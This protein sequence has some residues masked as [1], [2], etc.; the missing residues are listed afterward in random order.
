[1]THL[2]HL[3]AALVVAFHY[4]CIY[5]APILAATILPTVITG[6]TDRPSTKDGKL[7]QLAKLAVRFCGWAVHY[8]ETGSVKLPAAELLMLLWKGAVAIYRVFKP[9]P[10]L[11][12]LALGLLV[13]GCITSATK[14]GATLAQ[15]LKDDEAAVQMMATD[16]ATQCGPQFK[17]L[18][19]VF[20]D[21]LAVAADPTN[22][23]ADV[24][25]AAN[26][27][28]ILASDAK[29]TICVVTVIVKDLKALKPAKAALLDRLLLELDAQQSVA[30]LSVPVACDLL[31]GYD[32]KACRLLACD[33]DDVDCTAMA[34]GRFVQPL[35]QPPKATKPVKAENGYLDPMPLGSL[36]IGSAARGGVYMR[37]RYEPLA[38][39]VFG[40]PV[41]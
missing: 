11:L 4:F 24:L 21:I 40:L 27:Y 41:L 5:A 36:T 1:M 37:V 14:P 29:A 9:A 38:L 16:V 17:S 7:A 28:P 3:G 20:S 33:S 2:S 18:T 31:A 8:N 34:R 10:A 23:L 13:S 32:T 30:E 6:L 15:K 12:A 25:A 19:P 22:V 35:K 26:A 39:E